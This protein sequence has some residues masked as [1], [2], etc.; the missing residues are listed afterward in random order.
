MLFDLL[1]NTDELKYESWKSFVFGGFVSLFLGVALI[2]FAELTVLSIL[3]IILIY[4]IF[5]GL[6]SSF[7]LSKNSRLNILFWLKLLFLFVLI[8][9]I[10]L[11]GPIFLGWII[12]GVLMIFLGISLIF[13]SLIQFVIFRDLGIKLYGLT[14]FLTFILGVVL[15]IEPI[16][17]GNVLGI[18]V[19]VMMILVST[20]FF[21]QAIKI[22][23]KSRHVSIISKD[24]GKWINEKLKKNKKNKN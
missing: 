2:L 20:L 18:T 24:Q 8:I 6:I 12:G 16:I 11:F 17:F 21:Q 19:G 23:K 3:L 7:N 5:A 9:F 15:I 4:F 10:L 13:L 1:I 22:R 14:S